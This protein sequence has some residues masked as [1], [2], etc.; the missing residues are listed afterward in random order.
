M[1]HLKT[2]AR[3]IFGLPFLMFGINHFRY[4]DGMGAMV[5]SFIPGGVFWIYLTGAA[6]IAAS[7]S[8]ITT[9]MIRISTL[10]LALMLLIFVLTMHLPGLGDPE[11]GAM[12]MISLLKDLSLMGAALFVSENYKKQQ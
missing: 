10:L 5:P 3:I 2:I 9:K 12:A 6:L 7:I 8:I 1:K 4:A 11:H